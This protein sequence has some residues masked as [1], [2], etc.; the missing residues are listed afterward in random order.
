[1]KISH[2]QNIFLFQIKE[3]S[4]NFL[5]VVILY[6]LVIYFSVNNV[7][8]QNIYIMFFAECFIFLVSLFQF[9]IVLPEKTY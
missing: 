5:H 9:K 2:R 7:M 3:Q 1:M 6:D 4:C 8:Q